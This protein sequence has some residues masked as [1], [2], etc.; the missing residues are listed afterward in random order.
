MLNSSL[1]AP[2][3]AKALHLSS[4]ATCRTAFLARSL[5]LLS[6]PTPA[7]RPTA[8]LTQQRRANATFAQATDKVQLDRQETGEEVAG[9]TAADEGA[10][11]S[12]EEMK[13]ETRIDAET[14]PVEVEE[15]API[16]S[17]ENPTSPSAL[18]VDASSETADEALN[19]VL[20]AIHEEV[21]APT[22]PSTAEADDPYPSYLSSLASS[23]T[24]PPL[25][26]S[27][28]TPTAP[29]PPTPPAPVS[30]P[31]PEEAPQPLRGLNLPSNGP[32][33]T[34]LFSLRPKRFRLPTANSP[35]SHRLIYSKSWDAATTQLT[36]AFSKQQLFLFAGPDGLDL[37]LE[38]V[39]L[40]SATP[41]RKHKWW[42]SKRFDQMSKRELIHTILILEF[43]MV[44]PDTVVANPTL[45]PQTSEGASA[46]AFYFLFP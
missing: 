5:S 46:Y 1:R 8:R 44:H 2:A 42:K 6:T 36:R 22:A 4:T 11:E 31:T 26:S 39:R 10:V 7:S 29:P 21:D 45:G 34:D 24:S 15:S 25:S 33:L 37:N 38:D 28:S 3:C 12:A 9:T 32:Q 16:E 19:D 14:A 18:D 23:P 35:D 13:E 43:G 30:P 20:A 40:R 27:T 17:Q 41:G